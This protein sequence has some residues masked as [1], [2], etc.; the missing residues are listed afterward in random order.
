MAYD[1]M[2]D[3]L[4]SA[5]YLS[6]DQVPELYAKDWSEAAPHLP[7]VVLRPRNVQDLSDILSLATKTG[8]RLVTQG[9]RTGL[10]GGA[11]PQQS[12]WALTTERLT[13][14]IDI[15][16]IGKTIT[17]EAGVSLQTIQEAAREHGLMFPLDLGARGTATAGGIASTNAGGNQ[18]IQYGVTRQLILGLTAVLPDGR[19]IDQDNRLLKNNAGFDLKQLLIGSEGALGVIASVTFRLFPQK[20]IVKTAICAAKDFGAVTDLLFFAS[21]NFQGLSSF[22]VLWD[23]YM[24]QLIAVT[25]KSPLFEA[26]YPFHILLEVEAGEDTGH[27]ET[28]LMQAVEQGMVSDALIASSESQR[29][30]FWSYRDGIA[31][32]LMDFA[33]SV[34]FDIGIPITKMKDFTTEVAAALRTRFAG[35]RLVTFGHIG[36]G[37]LHICCT[38][39]NDNDQVPIEE[40]VFAKT[41][42]IGGTITAEH[43]IGILKKPWLKDCRSPEEIMVMK[44]L[45]ALFDPENI[46]NKG[47]VI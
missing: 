12:E 24:Q 38:T 26:P 7:E 45:K 6:G 15:D 25:D 20:D 31:D 5:L 11:T 13:K 3:E 21:K 30:T 14:I 44:Q 17:V 23:D 47:R 40:L 4:A 37:N 2:R 10:A 36:D 16:P 46:L 39:G 35:I 32:M 19:I 27:F 1:D 42:E 9:G 8:Q 33:P 18:V 29:Q 43:G 41:T 28:M 22:E 34:N